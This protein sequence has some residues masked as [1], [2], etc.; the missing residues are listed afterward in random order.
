[1]SIIGI[2][3]FTAGFL[4]AKKVHEQAMLAG[5]IPVRILRAAQFHE[6]VKDL[7]AW[8]TQDGVSYMPDWRSQLVAA[9]TVANALVD[10]ATVPDSA[11]TGDGA[12]RFPEIAGP[13]EESLLEMAR[14]LFTHRGEQVRIVEA[15]DPADPD[16]DL[17]AQGGLLPGPHA[18]LAGPTFEEWLESESRTLT[19]SERRAA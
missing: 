10:L 17:Y 1:V 5:P 4:A 7:A 6:F 14:L 9:R 13:R 18:T 3:G 2:D 19:S 11:L 16:G 15:S 12:A 8:G